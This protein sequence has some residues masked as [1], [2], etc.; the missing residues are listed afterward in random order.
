MYYTERK[1]LEGTR[2]EYRIAYLPSETDPK[3]I[4]PEHIGNI[5]YVELFPLFTAKIHNTEPL[6]YEVKE[7][8][9][10]YYLKTLLV[11]VKE[12]NNLFYSHFNINFS[13][14][15]IGPF[16]G[17][18]NL[19]IIVFQVKPID[20]NPKNIKK[21]NLTDSSEIPQEA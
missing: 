18:A 3:T 20:I 11:E 5:L 2:F 7:N 15:H 1:P 4:T 6:R 16:S 19:D 9:L 8:K 21:G 12:K 14:C 17:Q 10:W 13:D